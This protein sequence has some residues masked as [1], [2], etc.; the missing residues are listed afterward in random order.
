MVTRFK[1]VKA[2]DKHTLHK[3][4]T[5]AKGLPTGKRDGMTQ[6]IYINLG[7]ENLSGIVNPNP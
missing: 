3:L 7:R 1:I 5:H 4:L 2:P 6:I